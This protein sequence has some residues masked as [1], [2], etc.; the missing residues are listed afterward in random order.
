M[1][2]RLNGR[3]EKF[4]STSLSHEFSSLEI[5]QP[6]SPT[7]RLRKIGR[8]AVVLDADRYFMLPD[9]GVT[10]S[11]IEQED[12][13][14]GRQDSRHQVRFGQM[15]LNGQ[16]VHES[17]DFVAVKPF[18]D[19]KEL[20]TE[21]AANNYLNSVFDD[22][23]AFMSLG[24]MRDKHGGMNMISL[25]EHGVKTADTVF[26]ADKESEPEALRAKVIENTAITCM[27]SLGLMHGVRLVHGDAQ[28]KNLAWDN[29]QPRFVDLEGAA[30]I[31][32]DEVQEAIHI[33]KIMKDVQVFIESTMQ[34]EENQDQI[35]EVLRNPSVVNRLMKSYKK[36]I[37]EA[38]RQQPTSSTPNYAAI[39]EER[40]RDFIARTVK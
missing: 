36:G 10:A 3:S 30:L 37:D 24:V 5:E 32:K 39:N 35:A 26:W 4:G 22:Q 6:A 29:R 18:D 33:D 16:G 38:H 7:E 28:A 25:Y 34:V 12:F 9:H 31:P 21:W 40:T 15:I 11:F 13:S 20:Y 1:S 27:Y 8:G 23:R 14:Y 17:P 19:K 2:I